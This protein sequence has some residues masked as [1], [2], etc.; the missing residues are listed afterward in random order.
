MTLLEPPE[1]ET[2][3]EATATEV[4]CV[5]RTACCGSEGGKKIAGNCCLCGM[6]NP[7]MVWMPVTATKCVT[8]IE[9]RE[10]RF[11]SGRGGYVPRCVRG[12]A[13]QS[14]STGGTGS[15]MRDR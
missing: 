8:T 11:P 9:K 15:S 10:K 4:D 5:E 13:S 3:E 6:S 14:A 1:I 7:T 12:G 2:K